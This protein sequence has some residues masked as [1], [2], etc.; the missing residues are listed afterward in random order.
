LD[1]LIFSI[2]WKDCRPGPIAD[3][4][5][6]KQKTSKGMA[7]PALSDEDMLK[8]PNFLAGERTKT[9]SHPPF[10]ANSENFNDPRRILGITAQ[11]RGKTESHVGSAERWQMIQE[12]IDWARRSKK[13]RAAKFKGRMPG[14]AAQVVGKDEI[15]GRH[16]LIY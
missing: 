1:L 7:F 15:T 13:T 4:A 16:K 9:R 3:D 2:Q 11:R 5:P 6:L 14:G 12:M 10:K 8:M